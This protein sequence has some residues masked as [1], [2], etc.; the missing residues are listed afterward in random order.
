MRLKKTTLSSLVSFLIGVG[1][2]IALVGALSFFFSFIHISF[3]AA[4]LSALLGMLPGLLLVVF[5]EYMLIKSETLSELK[6]QSHLL[7]ELV[8][9]QD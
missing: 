9:R 6:H 3:F 1:W 4:L 7:E 5:L 8:V 2:G